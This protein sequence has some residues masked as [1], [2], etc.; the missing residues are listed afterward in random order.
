MWF[1]LPRICLICQIH[2]QDQQPICFF[3]QSQLLRLTDAC[4]SCGQPG[5]MICAR[6]HHQGSILHRF[7][8]PY[9]YC[10]PLKRL[11]H[12]FKSE[13][14]Q[15]LIQFLG[16]QLIKFLPTELIHS[17]CLIPVPLHPQ[18]LRQRGYHHTAMLAK[19]LSQALNIPWSLKYCIKSK[20]TQAQAKLA[21]DQRSYNLNDAFVFHLPPYAHITLIDD[22]A[23]T[24]HTLN[25]IAQGFAMLGIEKIDA[26]T[27]ARA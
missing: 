5:A 11:I 1:T 17:E 16:Q 7:Y 21:R 4:L 15:D 13:P 6:C 9:Q 2:H 24:G 3:C 14:S 23:T 20:T 19:F 27:L 18:R 10:S 25:Q 12:R 22:V 8:A 26:W